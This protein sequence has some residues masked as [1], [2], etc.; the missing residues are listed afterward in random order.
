[1]SINFNE[2]FDL[3]IPFINAEISKQ[4]STTQTVK[5]PFKALIVGQK[6]SLGTATQNTVLDIFSVN[7]AKSKFGKNSMLSHAVKSYFDNNKSVEL[8]VICL[9]DLVS[10][11]AATGTITL[12]GTATSSGTLNI[13][14]DGKSYKT[15]VSSGDTASTIAT[16]L[17]TTINND[18]EALVTSNVNSAVVTLTATH[19]GT[20]GNTIKIIENYNTDEV[21]PSG[22]TASIVDMSGGAGNPDL[23]TF[24]ISHLEEN[25]YNLITHP[26]T[27]NTTLNTISTALTDNFKATEMLDSFCV[28]GFEDTVSNM[29]T[30]SDAIN[31][32]FITILDTKNM[33]KNNLSV[34]AGVIGYIGDIAQS[35]PA[36]GY[37]GKELVN[38]LSLP[39]RIRTER[40]VLAGAGISTFTTQSSKVI[41][42]KT[43]TTY[44]KNS[45]GIEDKAFSELRVL[46]TLS[47]VRY[48]FIV[49]ISQFQN[50]KLGND[51]DIFGE[52]TNV[53]TPKIYKDNLILIYEALVKD[54]I[55][56]DLQNFEETIIATKNN[57]RIDASVNINIINVLEQQALK[58]NFK[59]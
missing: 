52:G 13:Y 19:K 30:K 32:P 48:N 27:D 51:G 23:S 41:N 22:I 44:V 21:T 17:N 58:I 36:S 3:N 28:V 59:V 25:Q 57:N 24:V 8:K 50:F 26:Y 7:E 56:E 5:Q 49:N 40:N 16:A 39:Q 33:F 18:D 2:I 6:T 55:C 29:T 10:G 45:L 46:L 47:Y 53:I 20:F 14:I 1:M 4:V 9:D 35:S 15:V 11:T 38:V 37:L 43:V 12:S 31:S 54:A 34:S 42:E